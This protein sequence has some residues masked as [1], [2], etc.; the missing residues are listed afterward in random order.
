M[1][2][3]PLDILVMTLSELQPGERFLYHT[4][5]LARDREDSYSVEQM[6]QMVWEAYSKGKVL[7][8]QVK[9]SKPETFE[10]FLIGAKRDDEKRRR[11]SVNFS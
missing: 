8:Y 3:V 4:G 7:L 10:Y 6:A 1:K 11:Y 5:F 2:A 9:T